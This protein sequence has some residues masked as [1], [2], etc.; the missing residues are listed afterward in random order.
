MRLFSCCQTRLHLVGALAQLGDLGGDRRQPLGR[1]LVLL[2]A[3]RLL[4]DRQ[5]RQTPLDLIDGVGAR[6]DLHLEPAGRLVHEVDRLVGELPSLD[7]SV[8]QA[9]RCNQGGVT[10]P[11]AMV[12]LVALLEAAQDRDRVLQRR[13]ADVDRLEAP[14]ER[15][16]LLD[17]LPVLVERRG[18][19]AAQIAARQRRLQH[20]GGVDRPLGSARADQ[21]V[22][23]VDEQ[24]DAAGGR[25]DLLEDGLEPLLE[26]AA[27]LRPGDE[28]AEI[29]RQNP[30]LPQRL[31]DVA[32]GDAQRDPLDDGR[33]ADARIA[34]QHRV[35]LGAARQDL[36]RAADLLV[37]ADDRIELAVAGQLGQVARVLR[38]RLVLPLGL[39]IGHALGAADLGQRLHE[40]LP[41]D[42]GVLQ[43]AAGGAVVL[44]QQRQQEVLARDVLVLELLGLLAG[45][46]EEGLQPPPERRCR[47][48]SPRT[49]GCASS[50][51]WRCLSDLRG[52]DSD[53]AQQRPGH[54]ILLIEQGQKQVLR[55]QFLVAAAPGQ[56][57]RGLDRLSGFDG[58]L[59]EPHGTAKQVSTTTGAT[60]R[61]A[62]AASTEPPRPRLGPIDKRTVPSRFRWV[63]YLVLARK[64]RPQRFSE[65]I[66][67]EHVART[68]TNAIA[69]NRVHHAFLFTGARGVGK[70]S[71][72]R[73]LAKALSC[74]KGPTAEPCGVCDICQEIAGGRSVDVIEIDAASNTKVEE[75]KSVLEGVRYLPARARRKVYI[76]DEVHML[77]AHSWNALLEDAGRAAAARGVRVR[78][79]RGAQDPGDDPVALPALRL[80]ADLDGAADR[81][82]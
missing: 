25:L 67:Q 73:I 1:G 69:Q 14:L 46:L 34:D 82:T 43:R 58:Q 19:D 16:V 28:R 50:A 63:S 41:A 30:L 55:R 52:V 56:L 71:A 13:L 44:G 24:D 61:G 68:L 72:A 9:R 5:R 4:L 76:I 78:H 36:H 54:A 21:R 2:L 8:R 31:G 18:A 81:P 20:V 48:S 75:T 6:I 33:L 62:V 26:L 15:L 60:S 51:L 38:Q 35:V 77:S 12:N 57:M 70:T 32:G 79:D 45:F 39:G 80:Q 3:E 17:V 47:R 64:Y 10:N 66:G 42:A 65:L 49:C 27:E 29:E 74:E 59:V 7:V 40:G 22:Q 37:A 53:L 11:D 23:L